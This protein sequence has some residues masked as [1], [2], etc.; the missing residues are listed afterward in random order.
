MAARASPTTTASNE[1]KVLQNNSVLPLS[2]KTS[3]RDKLVVLVSIKSH[4]R[5]RREKTVGL[6]KLARGRSQ[7]ITS[8]RLLRVGCA[9]LLW[10]R[11][12]RRRTAEADRRPQ[13]YRMYSGDR[14]KREDPEYMQRQAQVRSTSSAYCIELRRLAYTAG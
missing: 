9:V 4:A 11:T 7:R 5:A 10:A 14:C 6:N 3:T 1:Y 2:G 8:D 13:R 12:C